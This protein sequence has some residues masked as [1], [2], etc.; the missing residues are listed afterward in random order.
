MAKSNPNPGKLEA[1]ANALA[2]RGCTPVF[3]AVDGQL[4]ELLAVANPVRVGSVQAIQT[5]QQ[6]GTRVAMIT[7]DTSA[8]TQTVA[9]EVG[10]SCMWAKV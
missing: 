8:T 5:L 6:Q 7:G 1:Q 10:I 9:A 2:K 4:A 3:V